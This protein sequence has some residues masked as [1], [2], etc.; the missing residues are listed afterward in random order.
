MLSCSAVSS[1]EAVVM[2]SPFAVLMVVLFTLLLVG[3]GSSVPGL[4][5]VVSVAVLACFAVLPSA[6]V[7]S[8][9]LFSG[10]GSACLL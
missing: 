6:V 3:D 8:C 7:S 5:V 2:V 10:V 4:S 9:D 1:L